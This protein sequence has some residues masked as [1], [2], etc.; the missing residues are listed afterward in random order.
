MIDTVGLEGA[1]SLQVGLTRVHS[2]T[3]GTQ[4]CGSQR[5]S[6]FS[7]PSGNGGG[8]EQAR[9]ERSDTWEGGGE[10]KR[11]SEIRVAYL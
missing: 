9:D 2:I 10:R 1:C 3:L 6:S 5:R 7:C 11:Y 8:W 4:R